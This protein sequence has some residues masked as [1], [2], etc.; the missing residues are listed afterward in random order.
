MDRALHNSATILHEMKL[1]GFIRNCGFPLRSP[2][3]RTVAMSEIIVEERWRDVRRAH[4]LDAAGRVFAR[5]GFDEASVDDIAFEA[6]IG[7]PTVYR[8][9]PGKEALF[10]AVFERT[11]DELE[12]RLDLVLGEA[13]AFD[14]RLARF[15]GVL[16]P[17]FRTHIVSMRDLSE[18]G[19][20]SKRRVFRQR[21]GAIEARI[22]AL[23]AAARDKGEV[24]ETT[25]PAI[26]ARF[27]IGL[28]WSGTNSDLPDDAA[29]VAA[30]VDFAI[31]GLGGRRRQR[32]ARP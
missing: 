7:K 23:I 2:A 1:D 30:I 8:Y 19:E 24:A 14:E 11:L 22:E 29:I 15:L 27:M 20:T 10:Q 6:G 31:G 26:A 17:T 13:G 28:V 18:G 4:L 16:I 12:Q 32:R 5:L 3:S 9:Y 25:D 21:R